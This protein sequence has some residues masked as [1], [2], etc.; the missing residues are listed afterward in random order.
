MF[1]ESTLIEDIA[2][3]LIAERVRLGYSKADFAREVG[4]SRNT[5]RAYEMGESNIP[6]NVLVNMGAIGV[7]ILYLLFNERNIKLAESIA[8]KNRQQN[9]TA[10]DKI[11]NSAALNNSI[12]AGSGSTIHNISTTHHTTKTIAKVQ[13]GLEH[14]SNEQAS[15]IHNLVNEIA[16]C[17]KHVKKNPRNH[18]SIWSALNRYMKVPS[19]RLIEHTEFEKAVKYLRTTIGRLNSQKSAKT[20]LPSNEW[21]NRK[22]R[23]I[24]ASFTEYPELEDWFKMH[25]LK[26]YNTQNKSDLTDDQLAQAYTSL[27]NKKREIMKRKSI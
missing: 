27:A 21:R 13:P 7:D 4:I 23:Y 24:H 17:E 6:S 18:R 11:I 12:I 16:E 2:D 15:I 26:K 1:D 3:R 9:E 19:Y 8:D 20:K 25:I 22:Y 10:R 14:I 5:Y